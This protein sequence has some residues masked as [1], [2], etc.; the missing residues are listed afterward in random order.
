M[1]EILAFN[2]THLSTV[3]N[4]RVTM[5]RQASFELEARA[6]ASACATEKAAAYESQGF[7]RMRGQAA[8]AVE[9]CACVAVSVPSLT[10]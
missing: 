4:P 8:P 2:W 5:A 10:C 6:F 1:A 3:G 9:A 7:S